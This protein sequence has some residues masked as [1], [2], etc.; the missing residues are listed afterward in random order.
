[1]KKLEPLSKEDVLRAFGGG[2]EVCASVEELR[3]AFRKSG[4]GV[5]LWMSSGRFGNLDIE[6]LYD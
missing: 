3:E 2:V 6:G 5:H 4:S 1:M